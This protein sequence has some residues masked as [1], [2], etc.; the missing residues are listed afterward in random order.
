V[1]DIR[2]HSDRVRKVLSS[3]TEKIAP[4]R[5]VHAISMFK[6]MAMDL[7]DAWRQTV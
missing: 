2:R 4:T 3:M 5:Q 1:R 6:N 7:V